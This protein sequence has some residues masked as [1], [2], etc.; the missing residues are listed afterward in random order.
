MSP[1]ITELNKSKIMK[2]QFYSIIAMLIVVPMFLFTVHYATYSER[3]GDT[4]SDRII[5]DQLSQL[6][7]SVEL[8]T[9][10][11]MEISTRRAI[12]A[13]TNYVVNSGEFLA[14][15]DANIT[16]VML[17]GELNGSQ[18]FMMINNTM[19][20]WS[21]RISGK[22]VDFNVVLEYGNISVENNDGFSLLVGMDIN[23]TVSDKLY[24]AKIVKEGLRKYVTVSVIGIEDPIF[25]LNT[26]GFVRRM[27]RKADPSHV[28]MNVVTGSS[29]SSGTCSGPVTFNKSE[30][31]DSKILVAE[32]LTGV[33][34]TNHLGI[35]LEDE[36]NLTGDVD[37][38]VTGNGSAVSLVEEA[39]ASGYDVIYIDDET[40]SAWS[41]PVA[42]T[43]PER[44]YYRGEGPTFLQRLEG[45][46][47]PSQDGIFTFIYVPEIQEQALPIYDYSRVA[48][49]YFSDEG[50]CYQVNNMDE[51]FGID[52]TDAPELNL[53][54]MLTG[55]SCVVS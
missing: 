41:M 38:W 44:Y 1:L 39:I 52:G 6:E 35:I 37:C 2:G 32:N 55:T 48:Y 21:E 11:A 54:D 36:D 25:P 13:L 7:Y 31:D 30:V 43:L 46:Y 22:P 23:I 24:R 49:R 27:I 33:T 19:P 50:D 47:T 18:D 20:N 12:L 29:N 9:E 34:Y 45:D 8:D 51:W 15:A 40:K 42:E 3:L 16:Q 17:T 10:K 14:D 53:T 26:Q 5:S 28:N 4:V